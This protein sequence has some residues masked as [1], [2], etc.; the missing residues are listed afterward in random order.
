[1]TPYDVTRGQWVECVMGSV[2]RILFYFILLYIVSY[3][4]VMPATFITIDVIAANARK[5]YS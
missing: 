2:V 3:A 1:M 4:M 5:L